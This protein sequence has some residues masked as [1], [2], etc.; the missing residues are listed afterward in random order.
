[1]D[2]KRESSNGGFK[3]SFAQ[4]VAENVRNS[5][6]FAKQYQRNER[7]MDAV[8][9]NPFAYES[10]RSKDQ[11]Y[12]RS[13]PSPSSSGGRLSR[14]DGASLTSGY[15]DSESI[16]Y[17]HDDIFGKNK[18]PISKPF[19]VTKM[20]SIG[21]EQD[22][23]LLSVTDNRW[24]TSS[25]FA[26]LLDR[27]EEK[28]NE[29]DMNP[30]TILKQNKYNNYRGRSSLLKRTSNNYSMDEPYDSDKERGRN[31]IS[32]LDKDAQF[33]FRKLK[34]TCTELG[35][36]VSEQE[37]SLLAKSLVIGDNINFSKQDMLVK[38][39]DFFSA[40]HMLIKN[41][42]CVRNN[43]RKLKN[44]IHKCSMKSDSGGEME[45][46]RS[47]DSE[48]INDID[49]PKFN[50]RDGSQNTQHNQRNSVSSEDSAGRNKSTPSMDTE[51]PNTVDRLAEQL[52][53]RDMELL[54]SKLECQRLNKLMANVQ[55]KSDTIPEGISKL[56]HRKRNLE[57]EKEVD[58]LR[59]Q[60]KAMESSRKTYEEATQRLVSFLEQ[61]TTVLQ[62]TSP[63]QKKLL[64]S[65]RAEISKV[66][67]R[68]RIQGSQPYLQRAAKRFSLDSISQNS[69]MS[70]AESMP[71]LNSGFGGS[72]L[73][74]STNTTEESSANGGS[75]PLT[76]STGNKFSRKH[77]NE[78]S[79]RE[80]M[81]SRNS[82]DFSTG[83]NY[84]EKS[85]YKTLPSSHYTPSNNSRSVSVGKSK[86]KIKRS[87]ST[88]S[89]NVHTIGKPRHHSL[90]SGMHSRNQS[91][92]PSLKEQ[93][94]S[95][96][97]DDSEV[98]NYSQTSNCGESSKNRESRKERSS[99]V[100][101]IDLVSKE[102][103][104]ASS[105]K[106]VKKRSTSRSKSGSSTHRKKDSS[107]LVANFSNDHPN[108]EVC[109]DD[110]SLHRKS[111][112][113]GTQGDYTNQNNSKQNNL[114][115]V[116]KIGNGIC[117][118]ELSR[119]STLGA[120]LRQK[121]LQ[122]NENTICSSSDRNIIDSSTMSNQKEN[123]RKYIPKRST[124]SASIAN[125]A[126]KEHL[127][128]LDVIKDNQVSNSP[129]N[130][131]EIDTNTG[132]K[133]GRFSLGSIAANREP[134]QD[135]KTTNSVKS[136]AIPI[137]AVVQILKPPQKGNI[138]NADNVPTRESIITNDDPTGHVHDDDSSTKNAE[139]DL[140]GSI[141]QGEE[142]I[143]CSNADN[144]GPVISISTASPIAAESKSSTIQVLV[145]SNSNNPAALRSQ[146]KSGAEHGSTPFLRDQ[147]KFKSLGDLH[148][149]KG[150]PTV[151]R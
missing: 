66:A 47:S 11:V 73:S 118:D 95:V 123:N 96:H 69:I 108:I 137:E 138:D 76:G 34:K 25:Q 61:V 48:N 39:E 117:K 51:Y 52:A 41:K 28:D 110:E 151:P 93:E 46:C 124:S 101:E 12:E 55:L 103:A 106:S 15:F 58:Q 90:S 7:F 86:Q 130:T 131:N 142:S 127:V 50:I 74:L 4:E 135:S 91:P 38:N 63:V 29:F 53:E 31:S 3:S 16:D 97:P 56:Q 10:H 65:T 144:S 99:L 82:S 71:G 24:M 64:E 8:G 125:Q 26:D 67:R 136:D 105:L 85:G 150:L 20:P 43:E 81:S 119:N 87:Q 6:N 75:S 146:T 121:T 62:G 84:Y 79:I 70:R 149:E 32:Y 1:M 113:P 126:R 102:F 88:S 40:L 148:M 107:S 128:N 139:A 109:V 92:M 44:D 14:D 13:L 122:S 145:S 78:M 133:G 19:D 72:L 5:S 112:V 27:Q 100:P 114:K 17:N 30:A 49:L 42:H 35:F 9:S 80:S 115:Q 134:S 140:K 116:I 23:N 98:Y 2:G 120:A 60:L 22:P 37:W 143:T 129:L 77:P 94:F 104:Q 147:T 132:K 59:W 57:L 33:P 21:V 54:K 36:A 89:G 83:Q 18:K 68:A 45:S 141:A 111:N